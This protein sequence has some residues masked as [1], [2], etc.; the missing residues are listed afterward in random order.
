MTFSPIPTP[1]IPSNSGPAYVSLQGPLSERLVATLKAASAELARAFVFG[2]VPVESTHVTL[3]PVL[4]ASINL[5]LQAGKYRWV[6]H[7]DALYDSELL[8]FQ[9]TLVPDLA[10]GQWERLA[11]GAA[12]LSS[13]SL[14]ATSNADLVRALQMAM[15][16]FLNEGFLAV[17]KAEP[18]AE[19]PGPKPYGWDC[20]GV[21]VKSAR[22]VDVYR[23]EGESCVPLWD[24]APPPI[25]LYSE[26]LREAV[27]SAR[28]LVDHLDNL[29]ESRGE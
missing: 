27:I 9:A 2:S 23:S 22:V 8:K 18:K 15:A 14:T 29:I 12:R 17:V 3:T 21:V 25:G 20:G 1:A 11:E 5:V 7:P 13:L 6:A 10:S 28:N 19:T 4:E 24:V 26:Q 16:V